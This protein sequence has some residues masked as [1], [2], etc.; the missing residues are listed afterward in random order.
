MQISICKYQTDY[1]FIRREAMKKSNF[2]RRDF[3]KVTGLTLGATALAAC[4]P[5]ATQA[6][7]S[8]P[9]APVATSAPA[10]T[11]APA[12][13]K[14]Y[15]GKF[16]IMSAAGNTQNIQPWLDKMKAAFP[17]VDFDFRTLTSEKYTEL[18]AAS[19]V[20][21][22]QIDFLDLNGQDLRRYA[23]G[24]KALDLSNIAYKNRFRQV[25]LD[26][27]TVQGKLWALPVGGI[28]GFT[29]FYNKKL[30]DQVGYTKE[31]E[32][33][34][35]LKQLSAALKKAGLATFTH[36]GKNIYLWP[37]WQFWAYGQTSGNK[38]VENTFKTLAGDMKF[39]DPE[40]VAALQVLYQFAQDGMFIDG[41]NSLDSDAAWINFNGGKAAFYYTHSGQIGTYREGK[42]PNL[43]MNL[44]APVRVVQDANIK[45]NC[46]G[47]TG[48][49]EA[50][51]AK[52]APERKDLAMQLLD[53]WSSDESVKFFN[54]LNKDPA[55]TNTNVTAST[56]EI[57]VKY[58]KVCAD[59][60][61]TYL[62][63]FWPPEITRSFQENQQALVA[64]SKKPD[65]A[66]ADIQKALD[67]LYKTG[68]KFTI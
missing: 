59:N 64:G 24:G 21:G 60:Q 42:F 57:A 65:Q 43:D 61:T 36:A 38:S 1:Y 17:G 35:D 37:I 27:Y 56:D 68:Y 16:V 39:T 31:P 14:G 45:R 53:W 11:T 2:T 46:P 8:A 54:D 28:S 33:Y 26:T 67:A 32:T 49:A 4:A 9:A 34:D 22:D 12:A 30:L 5:A 6:P 25:G 63:W 40:H 18:F 58:A 23:T 62:D 15:Q 50:I 41:V 52:I 10:A 29:F 3:L 51:Y 13:A 55:S 7:T 66:A 48:S 47:G 44:I 20:A 19:E